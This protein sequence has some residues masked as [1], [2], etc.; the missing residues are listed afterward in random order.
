MRPVTAK[1]LLF[2]IWTSGGSASH[3]FLA[4]WSSKGW[5][6][7]VAALSDQNPDVQVV[8]APSLSAGARE[9]LKSKGVGWLDEEGRARIVIDSGLFVLLAENK[10]PTRSQPALVWTPSMVAVAEALLAKT[11]A[12]VDAIQNATRLS[13]GAVAKS[14][15]SLEMQEL[16]RRPGPKRGPRS[17]RQIVDHD[18]LLRAYAAAVARLHQK[19]TPI[20][21][22]RLWRDPVET[23]REEIAP[24]L[25]AD[26]HS[27]AVTGTMASE[28]MAPFLTEAGSL[29]I[30]VDADLFA[31]PTKLETLLGARRVEQGER[32]RIHKAP[33][34]LSTHGETISKV[35]VALPVRVFADLLSKGSRWAEAAEEL[36]E[37]V[38]D[39]SWA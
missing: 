33:T 35:R 12:T 10:T 13:Q 6:A 38:I 23:L 3:E 14:L 9:Y 7:N 24:A 30:Y 37:R 17:S 4:A 28:L 31:S 19:E 26:S 18:R 27:W 1:G 20:L 2:K 5:R 15:S 11:S 16:L 8:F 39:A 25:N 22:H 29:D 21:F 36:K 32:I 34:R